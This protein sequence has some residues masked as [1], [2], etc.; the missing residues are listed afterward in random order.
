ML[1]CKGLKLT[2]GEKVCV[3]VSPLAQVH[4]IECDPSLYRTDDCASVANYDLVSNDSRN[5]LRQCR[6]KLRDFP[7][8]HDHYNFLKCDWCISCF[9]FH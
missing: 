3:I 6:L 8:N 7:I 1:G 4:F 5:V 2:A 9:I